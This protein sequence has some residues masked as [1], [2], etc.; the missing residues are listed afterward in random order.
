VS[1]EQSTPWSEAGVTREVLLRTPI[2]DEAAGVLEREAKR[3]RASLGL[4]IVD[5]AMFPDEPFAPGCGFRMDAKHRWGA[6]SRVE[7]TE[8]R[9]RRVELH[10]TARDLEGASNASPSANHFKCEMSIALE[11]PEE[12]TDGMPS[13]EVP[14]Y[15]HLVEGVVVSELGPEPDETYQTF[16]DHDTSQLRYRVKIPLFDDQVIRVPFDPC[17]SSGHYYTPAYRDE[18]VLM[19]IG[20]DRA[21]VHRFLDWRDGI[22]EEKEQLNRIQLGKAP[23]NRACITQYYDGEDPVLSIERQHARDTA[24][25]EMKEGMLRIE[26]REQGA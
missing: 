5:L 23:D 15:P 26:V 16:E 10:A 12:E 3:V 2:R 13:F 22:R 7:D 19:A 25:I 6:R 1:E 14:E 4:L 21:E 20:F 24:T 8:W 11:R 17:F 18:R 9:V